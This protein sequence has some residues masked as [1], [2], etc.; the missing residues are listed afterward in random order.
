VLLFV[1][2]ARL[3]AEIVQSPSLKENR[4]AKNIQRLTALSRSSG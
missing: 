3:L 1:G 2:S 4:L